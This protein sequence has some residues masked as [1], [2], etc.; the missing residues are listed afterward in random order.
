MPEQ[1]ESAVATA[2]VLPA[3]SGIVNVYEPVHLADAF[4]IRLPSNASRNPE[5]LA[6]FIFSHQPSWIRGLMLVRDAVVGCFGLKTSKQLSAVGSDGKTSRIG[7]FRIYSKSETEI[8][9][10]EDDKHLNFRASVLCSVG[11]VPDM[12]PQLTISTVVQC[13]N[14]LGRAYILVIAPFHRIVVKAYLRRAAKIGWPQ[15]D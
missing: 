3:H 10:G 12:A 14:L 13:H 7:I 2:V 11:P 4:A 9:L 1:I 8:I 15:A 6:H 5:A